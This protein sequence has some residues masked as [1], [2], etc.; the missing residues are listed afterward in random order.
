MLGVGF[1]N[2][3][4]AAKHHEVGVCVWMSERRETMSV[5]HSKMN[6]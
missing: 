3:K 4:P 1:G 6:H 2:A 5:E